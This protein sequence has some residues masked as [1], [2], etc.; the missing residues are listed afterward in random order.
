MA[1]NWFTLACLGLVVAIFAGQLNL[2]PAFAQDTGDTSGGSAT[3][4]EN[5]DLPAMV[6]MTDDEEEDISESIQF[7]GS[8][9]EG[10]GFFWL[11]D[12]S[13]SMGWNGEI[14]ILKAEVTQAL[15]ALSSNA[16]F[17]LTWFSS[18]HGS[19]NPNPQKASS[20][21]RSAAI[22]WLNA[23]QPDG[24]TCMLPGAIA[25]MDIM[26]R[27]RKRNK[28]GIF[29]SDGEPNCPACGETNSGITGANYEN[30]PIHTIFIG[31][32]SS[33]Q[34]CMQGIANANGGTFRIVSN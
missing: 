22:G 10:D 24:A 23:L 27:S 29:V 31:N 33:G 28:Q 8:A 1:R 7:Y 34:Q 30:N 16:E 13:C 20:G 3:G 4:E 14:Q 17:G 25:A 15:N 9:Y 18:S 5:L 26:G 11:L 6:G 19:F 21:T 12:K 2:S 32:D